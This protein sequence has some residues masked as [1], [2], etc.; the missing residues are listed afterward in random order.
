MVVYPSNMP[1]IGKQLW[2][3]VFQT[4]P[5][6]LFFDA[7]K[8]FLEIFPKIWCQFFFQ[9]SCVLEELGIFECYWQIPRQKSVPV[10][11]FFSTIL[12][13]GGKSAQT[14]FEADLAPKNDFHTKMFWL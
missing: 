14:A 8:F 3:N 7:P 2:K 4:I 5:I 10:V 1:P 13:G 6:I 11:Y 9:E 12:G